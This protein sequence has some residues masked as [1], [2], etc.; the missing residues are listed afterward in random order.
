IVVAPGRG[1][2][3]VLRVGD[4]R[5]QPRVE[6]GADRLVEAP[7]GEALGLDVLAAAA[8][9][10]DAEDTVQDQLE[11]AESAAG[12][13]EH[14]DL[15]VRVGPRRRGGVPAD[16]LE[17]HA[18]REVEARA[19]LRKDLIPRAGRDAAAPADLRVGAD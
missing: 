15:A 8:S 11:L 14:L 7:A 5:L 6:A 1:G 12:G 13:D 18:G 19:R 4:F 3:R 9:G 2:A 17:A 16:G 10:L